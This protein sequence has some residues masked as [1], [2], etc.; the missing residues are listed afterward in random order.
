SWDNWKANAVSPFA[1]IKDHVL[2]PKASKLEEVNTEFT[3]KLNDS[4]LKEIVNQIPEDWLQWEDGAI[5]SDEIKE[6]YFQ[7]LSI[8]LANSQLFLKQAQDARK[9]LI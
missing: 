6:V 9:T 7:F 8:R 2:L 1:L 3:S 4:I 5:S